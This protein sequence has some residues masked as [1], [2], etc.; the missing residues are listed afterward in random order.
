MKFSDLNKARSEPARTEAPKKARPA[1]LAKQ[2]APAPAPEQAPAAE[3]PVEKAPRIEDR[4]DAVKSGAAAYKPRTRELRNAPREAVEPFRDLDA[5]ARD[6][7]ARVMKQAGEL[8]RHIDQPYTEKYEAILRACA[9]AADTLRTNSVLLNYANFS[10][11]ED[12]LHGHTANTTILALAMGLASDLDQAELNLLG[13]CAMAHDI[14][15]TGY[16]AI[17]RSEERLS[18]E[19][20]SEITLHTEAGAEKLDRIVDI[21]Y[22]IK[23]RAKRIILQT[24]ERMD[25]SGYPDRVTGEE[26]DPLAQLIGIADVY[27]A[28]THPRAWRGPLNPPDV[29]KELIEKEGRGFNSRAV[30][31]LISAL[32]IYPAGS[33]VALST[34]EI[35]KVIKVN[36]GSLTRPLVEIVL[37]AEFA[38]AAGHS[39]DLLEYPLTSIERTVDPAEIEQRNPKYFAKLDL[40]RWWVEW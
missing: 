14:G 7:Y 6:V 28:M 11:A 18:D 20:F 3:Q 15:M 40:A 9:L 29:I 23:D 5:K 25:G 13:F 17:Y 37:D 26:I 24:H 12:Y 19:Q 39:I 33:M 35:A 10:T 34:G 32:S 38:P 2:E 22:R 31:A 1:P 21:D 27:E 36:K 30:K 4:Q 16:D 8:L